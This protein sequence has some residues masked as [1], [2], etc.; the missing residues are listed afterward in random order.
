SRFLASL[1]T[2]RARSDRWSEQAERQLRALLADGAVW[3]LLKVPAE[4]R[5]TEAEPWARARVL[6]HLLAAGASADG[7]TDHG[8]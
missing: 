8:A 4:H 3:D 6:A 1:R 7:G 5:T 2:A